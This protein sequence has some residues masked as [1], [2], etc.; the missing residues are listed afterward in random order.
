MSFNSVLPSLYHRAAVRV[1][2]HSPPSISV[3]PI[4]YHLADVRVSVPS[5]TVGIGPIFM[6][7]LIRIFLIKVVA[8]A[9]LS[10]PYNLEHVIL[11]TTIRSNSKIA[12]ELVT[13]FALRLAVSCGVAS[14]GPNHISNVLRAP[15][16]RFSK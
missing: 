4:L 7:I 1:T 8:V 15:L 5:P 16:L 6:F 14:V 13:K 3:F 2:K 10:S 11:E 12:S 9:F